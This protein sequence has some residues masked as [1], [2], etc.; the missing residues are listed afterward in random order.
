MHTHSEEKSVEKVCFE[1]EHI[2]KN[3]ELIK[4]QFEKY[5]SEFIE[6]GNNSALTHEKLEQ[7]AKNFGID[8]PEHK[9]NIAEKYNKIINE[10]IAEFEKD[11]EKYLAIMNKDVLE[12]YEEDVNYFKEKVLR[13]ECPVIHSTLQNKKAKQLDKY[14]RDFSTAKPDDLLNVVT[15]L[16]DFVIEYTEKNKSNSFENITDYRELNLELLDT[17]EYTV[18]GVIGG[19]IKSMLLY[20]MNPELF[21]Y[22]SRE[23]IWALWYLTNKEILDCTMDSE[24]I[25]IDTDK[26][27]TQQNYFYPYCLFSYYALNILNLLNEKAKENGVVIP[28]KYRYVIVDAFMSFVARMH[29]EEIDLYTRNIGEDSYYGI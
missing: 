25:M 16:Y 14:R 12:A 29:Q 10:A 15:N 1:N 8:I 2:C 28:A 23:A 13:N 21:S 4:K 26:V 5:F 19:G 7:M 6:S 11:R 17:E 27:T 18:Y 20:K 9:V 24:F 22:R 3:I